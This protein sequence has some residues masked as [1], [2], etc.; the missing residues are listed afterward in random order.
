MLRRVRQRQ[1]C[2][3]K[4]PVTKDER[5]ALRAIAEKSTP[6]VAWYPHGPGDGYHPGQGSVRGPF[7]R[8]FLVSGGDNGMQ[9]PVKY[10]VPVAPLEDDA[11]FAAAAMNNLVPLLDE[12]D[13]R[14]KMIEELVLLRSLLDEMTV[15]ASAPVFKAMAAGLKDYQVADAIGDAVRARIDVYKAALKK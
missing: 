6:V 14:D 5:K 15:V 2:R 10:P 13:L 3:G 8:W 12:L 1:G 7:G 4:L 9:D 11:K